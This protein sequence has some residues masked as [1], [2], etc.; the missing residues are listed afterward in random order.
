MIHFY[1]SIVAKTLETIKEAYDCA[2]I[3]RDLIRIEQAKA[4]VNLYD[5]VTAAHQLDEEL[6]RK[7]PCIDAMINFANTML[8]PVP[9]S[10]KI[11][12]LSEAA[13]SDL[14]QDYYGILCDTAIKKAIVREMKQFIRSVD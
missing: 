8:P 9:Q 12:S 6:R 7:Y 3:L 1:D 13:V 5:G 10:R 2:D 14:T 11:Y 4:N